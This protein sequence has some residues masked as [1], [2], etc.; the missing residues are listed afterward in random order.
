MNVII[1]SNPKSQVS[2]LQ[3]KGQRKTSGWF[4][5]AAR[6]SVCSPLEPTVFLIQTGQLP[7]CWPGERAL[8]TVLNVVLRVCI[9]LH[10]RLSSHPWREL[11]RQHSMLS[12]ELCAVSYSLA[13]TE[14]DNRRQMNSTNAFQTWLFLN[15]KWGTLFIC[16][17]PALWPSTQLKCMLITCPW[18]LKRIHIKKEIR[19]TNR[20]HTCKRIADWLKCSTNEVSIQMC[21]CEFK[22]HG[23]KTGSTVFQWAVCNMSVDPQVYI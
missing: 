20:L 23:A 4:C 16:G 21:L 7:S 12:V 18:D 13:G 1:N 6:V 22:C 17:L 8:L 3:V 5:L 11:T 15:M 10:S 9:L 19:F 2:R 14:T